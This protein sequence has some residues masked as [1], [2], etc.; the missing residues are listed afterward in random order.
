MDISADEGWLTTTLQ[1]M[2]LVQMC[3]Q[4]RWVSDPSLLILP[5]LDHSHIEHLNKKLPKEGG[6]VELTSLPELMVLMEKRKEFL[7]SSLRDSRTLTTE[8]I[9]KVQYTGFFI[10][11]N[12]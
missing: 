12:K 11:I 5:H 2:H 4:G 9:S 7:H 10:Y 8:Q 6:V 3:V 1:L